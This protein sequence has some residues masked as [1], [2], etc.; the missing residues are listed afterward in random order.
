VLGGLLTPR[1]EIDSLFD[2]L[3]QWDLEFYTYIKYER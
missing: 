1:E 2:C 3:R